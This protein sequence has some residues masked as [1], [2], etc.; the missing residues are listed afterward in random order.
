M[1]PLQVLMLLLQVVLLGMVGWVVFFCIRVRAQSMIAQR[2]FKRVFKMDLKELLDSI[3][4]DDGPRRAPARAESPQHNA[5]AQHAAVISMIRRRV[6]MHVSGGERY[7]FKGK[8]VTP[9]M[10]D[11]MNDDEVEELYSRVQARIGAENCEALGD[12]LVSGAVAVAAL[13]L[14]ILPER[15]PVIEKNL[16]ANPRV[17]RSL[18]R[19]CYMLDSTYGDLLTPIIAACIIAKDCDWKQWIGGAAEG[20]TIE[21]IPDLEQHPADDAIEQYSA[22]YSA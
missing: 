4:D 6:A 10:V 12:T 1:D 15:Q 9:Q 21:E 16:K 3:P 18:E 22:P 11:S 8:T 2:K 14:P 13:V 7:S 17:R 20:A 19:F 5:E